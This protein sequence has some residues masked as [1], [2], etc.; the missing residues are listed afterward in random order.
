MPNVPNRLSSDPIDRKS[1][2]LSGYIYDLV[3]IIML[4]Q[5]MIYKTFIGIS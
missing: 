4:L 5:L 1:T 3:L 2:G